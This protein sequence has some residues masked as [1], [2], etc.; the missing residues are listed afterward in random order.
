MIFKVLIEINRCYSIYL[1]IVCFIY[2]VK[3]FFDIFNIDIIVN[4]IS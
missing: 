1:V 4:N 3:M 2:E